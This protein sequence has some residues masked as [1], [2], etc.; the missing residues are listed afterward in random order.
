[1]RGRAKRIVGAI[2]SEGIAIGAAPCDTCRFAET[3]KAEKLACEAFAMF[4]Q[5][6]NE[7]RWRVAPRAPSTAIY[8]RLGLDQV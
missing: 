1:M 4:L 8:A 5:T 6:G 3:C 2:E 7:Q